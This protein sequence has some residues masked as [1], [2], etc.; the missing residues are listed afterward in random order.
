MVFEADLAVRLPRGARV[1]GSEYD[2]MLLS[3]GSFG[4]ML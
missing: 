3:S 2:P 1:Q 4:V